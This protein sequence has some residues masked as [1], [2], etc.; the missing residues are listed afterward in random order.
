VR[1]K[2]LQ[3]SG[4]DF[5]GRGCLLEGFLSGKDLNSSGRSIQISL[6]PFGIPLP[7]LSNQ[8]NK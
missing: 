6:N 3:S 7:S 5:L 4:A 1:H 2:L 8:S